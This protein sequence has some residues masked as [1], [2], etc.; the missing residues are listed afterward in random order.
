MSL[1]KPFRTSS[2]P[3]YGVTMHYNKERTKVSA[4][5]HFPYVWVN[6]DQLHVDKS[7]YVDA[8]PVESEL[9]E[10]ASAMMCTITNLREQADKLNAHADSLEQHLNESMMLGAISEKEVIG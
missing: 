3:S 6:S 5:S 4:R 10:Y 2:E 7:T 9:F 8:T 1:D